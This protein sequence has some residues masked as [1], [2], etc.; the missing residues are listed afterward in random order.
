M[1][2][3]GRFKMKLKLSKKFVSHF[4]KYKIEYNQFGKDVYDMEK[5]PI[6]GKLTWNNPVDILWLYSTKNSE[7]YEGSQT[8][9]GIKKDGTVVWGYFSHCSCYGYESYTGDY[10][11]FE[12]KE[13]TFKAYEMENVDKDILNILKTRIQSMEDADVIEDIKEDKAKCSKKA[14]EV[15]N[16]KEK[17]LKEI[18]MKSII[19]TKASDTETIRVLAL[20]INNFKRV[21]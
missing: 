16:N 20:L 18:L 14:L 13:D 15:L 8:Q 17:E 19:D 12:D 5:R 2:R 11:E 7:G 3:D 21:K 1:G 6:V 10:K 4:E 9:I